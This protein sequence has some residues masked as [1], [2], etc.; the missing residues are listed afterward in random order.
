MKEMGFM[1]TALPYNKV[2]SFYTNIGQHERVPLVMAEMK[3]NGIVPNY[4]S[5]N[6]C[7]NAYGTRADFFGLECEPQIVVD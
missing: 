6:I 3:S 5:Y 4:F 1:F 7:I 2:M